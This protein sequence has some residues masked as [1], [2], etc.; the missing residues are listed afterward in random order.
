MDDAL[1]SAAARLLEARTEYDVAKSQYKA[2]EVALRSAKITYEAL[3]ASRT[4]T[5]PRS[6][7][8]QNVLCGSCQA[9][10]FASYFKAGQSKSKPYRRKVGDLF[11]AVNNQSSC[12]FC[13]F[14][15]ESFQIGSVSSSERLHAHLK[16][17][18]TAIYFASDPDGKAWYTKAGVDTTL[19]PC[20]FA[21]LQTGPP[22][23]IGEPHVC[24]A[25]E[26]HLKNGNDRKIEIP[27]AYA[28]PRK[29]EPL[30][31]FNGALNYDLVKLWLQKCY[32]E[33][34]NECEVEDVLSTL[35]LDIYL[36]DVKARRIVR[37]CPGDRF[38]ALS[39]VWGTKAQHGAT[40]NARDGNVSQ[41]SMVTD[42]THPD[43]PQALPAILP[44]TMEDAMQFVD[45]IGERFV[46]IDQIC[47][48]QREGEHKNQQI[49]IM[50]QIYTSALLTLV[51][52][53]GIDDE[54]GLP[55]VSRP[56]QQTHQPSVKLDEGELTATFIYSN[57]DNNGIS[58]WDTRGWT[59]QERLLSR[60][61][62]IFAKAYI[63]MHCRTE[64]FHDCLAFDPVRKN[65]ETWLGHDYFREDGSGINLDDTE[66]DFKTYDSLIS[67]FTSRQLTHKKD[68][69]D[70]CRGSLNRL[71][72]SSSIKFSFGLPTND[73]LRALIWV[74]HPAHVL[75]RRAGFPSWSWTGW[76]GRI[77][78]QYWVGDMAGYVDQDPR[79]HMPSQS[80]NLKRK[81]LQTPG[82]DSY[83]MERAKV[84]E[85]P[86]ETRAASLELE[87]TS[88]K[89]K[90]R[91]MRRHG[92]THDKLKPNSRQSKSA[93]GDHWTLLGGDNTP[94]HDEA[95]EYEIFEKRDSFFRVQ[96]EYSELL[97]TQGDKAELIFIEHWP[98][99]RDSE[100]S[101]KWL[102]SMVSALIVM[103]NID[104]TVSRLASVLLK[105]DDWYARDP[106]PRTVHLV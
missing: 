45:Q 18:D 41:D 40:S 88:A 25:F 85:V 32:N 68:I 64:F 35:P 102:Y 104:G 31:A 30:E 74:P 81:R 90:M 83:H 12:V 51:N 8:N 86:S 10:P 89:F 82:I 78:Y 36:V 15:I 37:R 91:L 1:T 13:K 77:E 7:T 17:R 38:I 103:E 56:L 27:R 50:D 47:I 60:R 5:A 106:Q 55:G 72:H 57:W 62:L 87:T 61:C 42:R 43:F 97:L 3:E 24:V 23:A 71:S 26:E 101:N 96:S 22:T 14:L 70:A 100:A 66:W 4:I 80:L 95:G 16:P 75:A 34:G 67:V 9:I 63:A 59:L 73:L 28:L 49:N 79:E 69:L 44:Q 48:D 76:V 11:H 29:R 94:L 19:A 65:V 54:W 20:P 92:E 39:Y 58:I 84:L 33:H 52:L 6:N 46:W 93:I 98:Y 105:G 53:N 99:I 21:W 2:A